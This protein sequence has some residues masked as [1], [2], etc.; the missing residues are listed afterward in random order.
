MSEH[1][2]YI[3]HAVNADI[4]KPLPQNEILKLKR[5]IIGEQNAHKFTVFYNSRNARR[6]MTAQIMLNFKQFIDKVGE[7]KAFLFMHTDP[8]DQEGSNL[9]MVADMLG[10]KNNQFMFSREGLPP[11]KIAE[12]YNISDVTVNLSNNEG[13][14][15]SVLESLTC[16]TL[17]I[18]NKT[19]GLQDQIQ[20][21]NGIVFGACIEPATKTI[22]GSQSIPYIFDCRVSDSDAVNAFCKLY[23]MTSTERNTL[24]LKA[25]D[26]TQT[27]FSMQKMVN[28]WDNAI[29]KYTEQYKHN[30]TKIKTCIL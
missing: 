30:F 11:E 21:Y 10:L 6:K 27:A 26:W 9:L 12:F 15:L 28:A 1:S 22:Q 4:F 2:E 7:D 24:G 5:S 17:A 16:G 8:F 25:R 29:T 19:G 13:W 3:P 20:D 23:N 18:V 14:G